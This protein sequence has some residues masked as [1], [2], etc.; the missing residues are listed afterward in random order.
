M[1]KVL[2]DT[3]DFFV[4]R[5]ATNRL[6]DQPECVR[7]AL[8]LLDK[9]ALWKPRGADAKKASHAVQHAFLDSIYFMF[10]DSQETTFFKR[11][12]RACGKECARFVVGFGLQKHRYAKEFWRYSKHG[13]AQPIVRY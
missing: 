3:V 13:L 8:R 1:S 9:H 4:E 10:G 11:W 12:D 6:R 7:T 5:L 2:A